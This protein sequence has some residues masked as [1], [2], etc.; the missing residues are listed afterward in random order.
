[1]KNTQSQPR[2][3]LY[4]RQRLHDPITIKFERIEMVG[5]IWATVFPSW[6]KQGKRLRGQISLQECFTLKFCPSELTEEQFDMIKNS[7]IVCR[8]FFR[9]R[10]NADN[11]PNKE[12]GIWERTKGKIEDYIQKYQHLLPAEA[13][14]ETPAE[15]PAPENIS[16]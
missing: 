16:N 4:K 14:P 11:D 12:V 2:E 15:Q 1:M 6:G 7:P 9:F 3:Y 10:K 13:E 5:K 8:Q